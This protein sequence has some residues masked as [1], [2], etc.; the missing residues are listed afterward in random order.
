MKNQRKE[1]RSLAHPLFQYI[2][3]LYCLVAV[4]VTCIH[5][6]EEYAFTKNAIAKELETYQSTFSPILE[7]AL[8]NLDKAQIDVATKA[9]VSVP[10]I[11]GIEIERYQDDQ[12]KP[13]SSRFSNTSKNNSHQQF[14]YSFPITDQSENNEQPIG[15]VILYSDTSMVLERLRSGFTF[16]I[17]NALIKAIALGLILWW[18]NKRLLKRPL[19]SSK[20]ALDL[21]S[22][23][24]AKSKFLSTMNHELRTPMGGI[25]GALYLLGETNPTAKQ[26]EYLNIADISSHKMLQLISDMLDIIKIDSGELQLNN[27]NFDLYSSLE[28]LYKA[29]KEKNKNPTVDIIFNAD[30][31]KNTLVYGDKER[32][33]QIFEYII[34]N[35]LKFTESGYIKVDIQKE[36]VTESGRESV[37]LYASIADTGIGISTKRIA[38]LFDSLLLADSSSSREHEEAGLGLSICKS[39]CEMMGGS[40]SVTSQL[41]EGSIFKFDIVM[42]LAQS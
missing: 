34:S 40:I 28:A 33:I 15:K 4:L 41:D 30:S 10:I 36:E 12:L 18:V 22:S 19:D 21:E 31:I 5:L 25:Q 37:R 38:T 32:V 2:F 7:Q 6:Y 39:L 35:A 9:V 20:A 27:A 23:N 42:P 26:L 29:E 14:S 1:N 8:W 24:K 16:I 3:G 13:Y 17:V 11:V